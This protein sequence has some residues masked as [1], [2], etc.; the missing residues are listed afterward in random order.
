MKKLTNC[1]LG[2][3]KTC[4]PV[5]FMRQ[6]GRYLPEFRKIR[7]QNP[8]FIKLCLNDKLSSTITLQPL[9]RFNLDAAIIFSDILMVPYGLGQK[10]S[11]I[12][13]KGPVLSKLN[14]NN[15]IKMSENDFVKKIKPVYSAIK[16]TRNKLNKNNSL[17]SFVGAPWTLAVY[18]LG[19]KKEKNVLDLKKYKEKKQ[20]IDLIIKKLNNFLCIHIEQQMNAGA[21]VVQIFD[22]WAGLLPKSNLKKHCYTP[23]TKLVNFCKKNN[24]PVICFPKGIKKNYLNF[25]KTVKPDGIS[26]DYT[27]DPKWARDNFGGTCIQGGMDPKTLMLEENE[28]LAEAGKYLEIFKNYPYI[29]NLGH[30][31]LPQT[32]PIKLGKLI[33]FVKNYK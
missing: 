32:D 2:K 5:W 11:F 14:I 26:I 13:D 12:K 28:I 23:N 30:G 31:L 33:N 19:L 7:S 20:E 10:V 9:K 3:K 24:F 27:I 17:I 4:L 22:S 25:L 15:F 18:M 29:F 16:K 6:A 8:N 1:L 21:D